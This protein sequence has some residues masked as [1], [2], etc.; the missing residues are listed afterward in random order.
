MNICEGLGKIEG[1]SFIYRNGG[2]I[3]I[4]AN[5]SHTLARVIFQVDSRV[6]FIKMSQKRLVKVTLSN[7][8][9]HSRKIFLK[10]RFTC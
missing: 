7:M 5:L 8:N 2:V 3:D 6:C 4:F 1:T 9:A 10:S